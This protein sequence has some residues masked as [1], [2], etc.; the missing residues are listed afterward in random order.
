MKCYC[1]KTLAS[2]RPKKRTDPKSKN[3]PDVKMYKVLSTH[4]EGH[5]AATKKQLIMNLDIEVEKPAHQAVLSQFAETKAT[6]DEANKP[7][8]KLKLSVDEMRLKRVQADLAASAATV[9]EIDG[10][11]S[12]YLAPIKD[13]LIRVYAQLREMTHK[14]H[15]QALDNDADKQGAL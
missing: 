12:S 2:A 11:P 15:D 1:D 10:K 4:A 8:K 7:S 13:N 6:D 3:D 9:L 14:V 5:R